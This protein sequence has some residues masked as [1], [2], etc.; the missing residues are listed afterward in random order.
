MAMNHENVWNMYRNQPRRFYAFIHECMNASV[1]I[2]GRGTDDNDYY[3]EYRRVVEEG[4]LYAF[5]HCFEP[6]DSML[7]AHIG[8]FIGV[9]EP[10]AIIRTIDY[11][12]GGNILDSITNECV[13][14]ELALMDEDFKH[15]ENCFGEIVR[16]YFGE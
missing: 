3:G 12:V 4:M 6:H 7:A 15:F 8:A 14:V 16:R 5:E 13:Y 11:G 1:G 10:A 9:Y 2:E